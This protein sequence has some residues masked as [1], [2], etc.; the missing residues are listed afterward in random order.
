MKE[1]LTAPL[2][3]A[4][5]AQLAEADLVG[6]PEQLDSALCRPQE[7]Q[8]ELSPSWEQHKRQRSPGREPHNT[9]ADIGKRVATHKT[10]CEEHL[11]ATVPQSLSTLEEQRSFEEKL[12]LGL[13][14][15][16][17]KF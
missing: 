1:L 11:Q 12:L 10:L 7:G 4:C 14:W 6:Q 15:D 16:K 2:Q 13:L 9:L 17:T 8:A 3:W 5:L